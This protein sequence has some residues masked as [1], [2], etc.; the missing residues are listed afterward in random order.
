MKKI[1]FFITV[2]ALQSCSVLDS[3]SPK[4]YLGKWQGVEAKGTRD[5]VGNGGLTDFKYSIA[6]QEMEFTKDDKI[7]VNGS[8]STYSINGSTLTFSSG[9]TCS[10]LKGTNNE[11]YLDFDT[12]QYNK[13]NGTKLKF[14]ILRFTYKK[15]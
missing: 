12:D 3:I 8:A 14:A 15:S 4:W 9:T 13:A 2:L 6:S 7:I 1:L 10:I 5:L 11:M